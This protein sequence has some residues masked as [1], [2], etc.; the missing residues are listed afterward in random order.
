[1][2]SIGAG[3][4]H[5]NNNLK[6]VLSFVN[7]SNQVLSFE[8]IKRQEVIQ[9]LDSKIKSIEVGTKLTRLTLCHDGKSCINFAVPHNGESIIADEIKILAMKSSKFF[10]KECQHK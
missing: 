4:K 9:F 6:I 1:M 5:I 8:D 7:F 2:K 3:D 10:W